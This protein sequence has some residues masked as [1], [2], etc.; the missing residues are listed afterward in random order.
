MRQAEGG[1][2]EK[3][4]KAEGRQSG[5]VDSGE[6]AGPVRRATCMCLRCVGRPVRRSSGP[7][8]RQRLPNILSRLSDIPSYE[9]GII[10]KS[11]PSHNVVVVHLGFQYLGQEHLCTHV[12]VCLS[13]SLLHG[14]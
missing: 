12:T 10:L 6:R 13:L 4:G 3:V 5:D 8:E 7:S 14:G 1:R 9:Y 2:R 11:F